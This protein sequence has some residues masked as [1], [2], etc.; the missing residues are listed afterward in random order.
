[1]KILATGQV[2]LVESLYQT[3]AMTS[4]VRPD[5]EFVI[6][7]VEDVA[8]RA[9]IRDSGTPNSAAPRPLLLAVLTLVQLAVCPCFGHRSLARQ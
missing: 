7:M 1:L 2:R 5:L 4:P 8:E 3:G 9:G 6:G